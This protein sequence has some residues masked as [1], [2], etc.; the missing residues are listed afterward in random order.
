M[1]RRIEA[2][3]TDKVSFR[4]IW[5]KTKRADLL[6]SADN[7][8]VSLYDE[9]HPSL[10]LGLPFFEMTVGKN[11]LAWPRLEDLFPTSFPG[12]KT[13]RDDLVTDIDRSEEHTSEIQS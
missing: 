9:I 1:V 3:G 10:D 4:H 2:K 8:G 7:D 5:G 12:V 11:Y 6:A 13:S